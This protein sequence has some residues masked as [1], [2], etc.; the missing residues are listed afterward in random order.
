VGSSGASSVLDGVAVVFADP[1]GN[2]IPV[3]DQDGA[4]CVTPCG[5]TATPTPVATVTATLEPAASATV[6]LPNNLGEIAFPSGLVTTTTTFTYTQIIT[7]TQNTGAFAFA[8]R[9]FTLVATDANGQPITT[10]SG[11]FTITLNYSDADWQ[12]AGIPGENNLNL[13]YWDGAGWAAVLPCAGCSLDTVNNRVVAALDHLTEFGLLGERSQPA[14]LSLIPGWNLIALP[15]RPANDS[16]AA[17][18]AP[19]AGQYTAVYAYDACDVADPWKKYDPTAPPFVNDLTSIDVQHGYWIQATGVVNLPLAGALPG[20]T[21]IPLCLGWNLI[22][23]PSAAAVALPDA[24]VGITGKYDLVYA[25]DAADTVD[26]WKKFAPSAPPF[27]NDLTEL[28][29]GKGYW[30]RMSANATLG[31]GP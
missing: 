22:G 15:R 19:I 24:L 30:I 16:P 26:P 11:R 27:V 17:V 18:L 12:A 3:T 23:Y 21:S 7:P 25:Y 9:S 13:Y 10:F 28:E 4:V 6:T 2:P 14:L 8:G 29:P 20:T 5:P 31:V 1:D